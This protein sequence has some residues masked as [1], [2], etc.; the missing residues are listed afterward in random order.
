MKSKAFAEMRLSRQDLLP[1]D[2]KPL[3]TLAEAVEA[4]KRILGRLYGQVAKAS[5]SRID[6]RGV[7][8]DRRVPSPHRR[9]DH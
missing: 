5:V 3:L 9:G 1:H 7:A 4:V 6:S 8:W 2:G